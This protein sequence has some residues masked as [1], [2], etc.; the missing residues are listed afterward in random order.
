MTDRMI[1]TPVGRVEDPELV[2]GRGRFVDDIHLPGMLAACFL[3]SPFAHARL[4]AID[5]R[6][7]LDCPGVV[8]V[9]THADI[10]AHLT[11]DKLTDGL[12]TRAF[13]Q[14][15]DRLVLASDE[16]RHVGEAVAVVIAETRYLA[17]DAAERIEVE[18]DP[19]PV[20]AD[21]RAALEPGAPTAHEAAADNLV[22]G[23]SIGYGDVDAA[24]ARAEHVFSETCFQ[25]KGCGHAIECR[26]MV[27]TI[28][29]VSDRLN[30]WTST[31][32]PHGAKR[33]LVRLLGCDEDD[34]AVVTPDI[35]GGFGP[36]LVFYPEEIVL[37]VA[38]RL[39]GKPVKWIEDRREHFTATT[40]ERDQYWDLEAAVD[41]DGR[42]LALR[43]SMIHDHGAYTA[44]GLNLPYNAASNVPGPYHLDNF[45]FDV[46]LA[47][48]NKVPVTPVR[49]AGHPQGTFAM[50]R[51]IDR[52]ADG[53]GID[54]AEIRRRNMV[55]ADEMPYT[56]AL[57]TRG[58]A[59]IVLDSGDYPGCL[60]LA[61]EAADYRGFAARRDAAARRGRYLGI[62][63]GSYIK[64][65]GRG[66]FEAANV[67]IG[68]SGRISLYTGATAIGQGTRTMLAQIVADAFGADV[69]DIRVVTGDTTAIAIG[70]GASAS[71]Q[72]VTAGSSAHVAAV[73]LRDKVLRIAATL[74]EASEADLEI[75]DGRV[76]VRGVPGM[77]VGL[78]DIAAAAAGTAGYAMPG[79]EKPGL[80][81]HA[82][83]LFD[84]M[85]Y[86]GGT[87]V[88]EVEIDI[89][90]GEVT[91]LGYRIS[92]DCGRMINPM[93]VDGQVLG[94][95]VHGIG[96]SLYE[97][98]IYDDA[99]QPQTTTLAEY[100][101]PTATQ[102]PPIEV[103][104]NDFPTPLNPLGIKGVGESGTIPAPAA[105]ISAVENALAPFGV[106]ISETPITPQ[107]IIELVAAARGRG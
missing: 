103:I 100:L 24:F 97:R 106:R 104:H 5:A 98:I 107:R 63:I 2:A 6:A 4:G 74:L 9:F 79:G 73:E 76:G 72:A 61:L 25:H 105:V 34:V 89:E 88:V 86:S 83:E 8:A 45:Q 46:R 27:A 65:T 66:P 67:R 29:P 99:A 47:L 68:P 82:A 81:T 85:T 7:A 90:T 28:D 62:G 51:L 75:A 59:D 1:G 22:G 23:F 16:V 26:G 48:T 32:M 3:R 50:E 57:K 10:A 39:V 53:L 70:I 78:A 43:G 40:Q 60:D 21:A 56:R 92:H 84:A 17:E 95:T 11:T 96:N 71:R 91:I 41:G 13:N 102:V 80:E 52:V 15:V 49:G 54:R 64:G 87:H 42:L 33:M 38:T 36:K 20:V 94:G 19:L 14:V 93:M 55:R 18:Y 44:R 12:P 30:M 35:G 58:G 31:Q 37:A 69:G 77:A 101:M